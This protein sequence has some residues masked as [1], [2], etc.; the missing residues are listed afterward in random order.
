M[1]SPRLLYFL[2]DYTG[3]ISSLALKHIE[4]VTYLLDVVYT[5]SCSGHINKRA[6]R[7]PLLLV[8][9]MTEEAPLNEL[10]WALCQAVSLANKMVSQRRLVMHAVNSEQEAGMRHAR[11]AW[12]I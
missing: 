6:G 12:A 7:S 3:K 2:R 8:Q 10:T 1:T 5:R 9:W 4:N 11:Q